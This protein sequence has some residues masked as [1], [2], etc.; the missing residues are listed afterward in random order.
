MVETTDITS[1]QT[2]RMLAPD[3]VYVIREAILDDLPALV[4]HRRQMYLDIGYTDLARLEAL[5]AHFARWAADRL[6]D[7]RY[8]EWLVETAA[9]EIVAGAG[10]WL[11]DWPP[12]MMDFSPLRGYVMNVFTAPGYRGRGL[13]KQAVR[14]ILDWCQAHDIHTVSLHA[15]DCGRPVYESLGFEPTNELRLQM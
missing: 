1:T 6:V 11:V 13:A 5:L 15:S 14:A 12:Q 7:G 10:L 3:T 4:A 2:L 9:G 8:H